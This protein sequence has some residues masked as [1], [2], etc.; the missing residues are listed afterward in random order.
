MNQ[1]NSVFVKKAEFFR[2]MVVHFVLAFVIAPFITSCSGSKS[3]ALRSTVG[4]KDA[5]TVTPITKTV[6][7]GGTVNLKASGGSGAYSFDVYYG[8]G[9]LT[10][11]GDTSTFQAPLTEGSAVV[12][13]QDSDSGIGYAMIDISDA[14]VI[15]PTSKTL[16]VGNKF[17]F[18]VMRG[19]AP[20]SFAVVTGPGTI[21]ATTGEFTAGATTGNVTVRVTDAG[22]RTADANVTVNGAIT[23]S[24]KNVY[25]QKESTTTLQVTGG[26]PPYRFAMASGLGSVDASTGI[27]TAPSGLGASG[28]YV[29]DSAGNFDLAIVNTTS[30]L[31]ISPS[32][33]LI[34]KNGTLVFSS[35][36][37]VPPYQFT[38]KQGTG[39]IGTLTGLYMAPGSSTSEVIEV[40]DGNGQTSDATV[41]VTDNLSFSVETIALAVGNTVDVSTYVTGGVQPLNYLAGNGQGTF[42]GS[43]YT[44]PNVP[45]VYTV[46]VNDSSAPTP[47]SVTTKMIVN[48]A[49]ILSPTSAAVST[50]GKKSFSASGGV[51]PYTYGMSAGGGTINPT[52]GVYMAPGS[53]S[54]SV[55]VM[56]T[57]ARGN[58]ATANVTVQNPLA[59]D[60]NNK[61]LSA[62][63][64]F[65]FSASGGTGNYR[66]S[67]TS[68][69]IDPNTGVYTAPGSSGLGTVFVT[70]GVDTVS[71]QI[72]VLSVLSIKPD[73]INLAKGSSMQFKGSG[74]SGHY[75]YSVIGDGT[76][77]P[78]GL[79]TAPS[80][81]K[82]ETVR[83]TDQMFSSVSADAQVVVYDGLTISPPTAKLAVNQTLSFTGKYGV[84]GY[85]FTLK[86]GG[87]GSITTD[88]VYTSGSQAGNATV[89][90]TDKDLNTAEALVTVSSG[91]QITPQQKIL[92]VNN[93]WT[94][95]ASGGVPPYKFT[96]SGGGTISATG[97][98]T[99]P[100]T[101]ASNV[102]VTVTDS[103]LVPSEATATVT[104][105]G[106]LALDPMNPKVTAGGTV[107]FTP[108]GGSV[109][110]LSDYQFSILANGAGSF[111]GNTY[112]APSDPAGGSATIQVK[113]TMG[114]TVSTLVTVMP[115]SVAITMPNSS[116]KISSS[117]QSAVHVAGTCTENGRT[118]HVAVS[119]SSVTANPTCSANAWDIPALDMSSVAD[120][121]V[122][123]TADHA[124]SFGVNAVQSSVTISKDGSPPTISISSPTANAYVG[125]SVT[126]TGPCTKVGSVTV[127]VGGITGSP[128]C[129]GT[130]YSG[131][132]N[133]TSL[134]DGPLTIG[135]VHTDQTGNISSTVSVNVIKDGTAPTIS[136]FTITN[137]SPTNN[138][139]FNL[140]STASDNVGI[141]SYC[142]LENN[143]LVSS[144]TWVNGSSLP[145]S[146][147][148]TNTNIGKTL[149]AWV[150]DAAGNIS[151]MAS[152]GPV[153]LDTVVPD[154]PTSLTVTTSSPNT[155][156]TPTISVGGITNGDSVMIYDGAGCTTQVATLNNAVVT[157]GLVTLTSSTLTSGTHEFHAKRRTAAGNTSLCSTASATYVLDLDPPT[158]TN[159]SATPTTGSYGLGGV[160]TIQVTFSENVVVNGNPR[161]YL[162]LGQGPTASAAVYDPTTSANNVL[163]FK[164]T[165]AANDS[166]GH[167]DYVSTSSFA[168]N[169]ATIKDVLQNSQTS[170]TLPVPGA[171]GSLGINTTIS[172]ITQADQAPT[173]VKVTN[174]TAS[175]SNIQKP[176]IQVE[177]VANQD[178]VS[179]FTDSNC[180]VANLI[181]TGK[182]S[183]A[184]I[185]VIPSAN[186]PE[187]GGTPY[188]FYANRKNSLGNTSA[189]SAASDPYVVDITAPTVQNVTSITANGAYKA[190]SLIYIQI[191]FSEPVVV[192][193]TPQLAMNTSVNAIYDSG[194]NTTTLTF[195]YTVGNTDNVDY[196]DYSSTSALSGTIKDQAGNALSAVLATPGGTGSLR[197]NKHITLDTTAPTA[198]S[199]LSL[200]SP[201]SS[202][203]N[204]ATPTIR[205]SGL[206]SGDTVN[207]FA[208]ASGSGCTT[209]SKVNGVVGANNSSIDLTSSALA[210]DPAT[211][212]YFYANSTDVAGNVS[213]C[214]SVSAI[215][216][217]DTTQARVINVTASGNGPWKAADTFTISIQFNKTV[218]VSGTAPVLNLSTTRA[219]AQ[220]TFYS[221]SGST[222]LVFQYQVQAGDTTSAASPLSYTNVNALV[223]T[224][225]DNAGNSAILTL[226]TIGQTGS[227]TANNTVVLDTTAPT[228]PTN[229]LDGTWFSS[230]TSSPAITF[231]AG[232]DSGSGIRKHQ[233]QIVLGSNT[234]TVVS[235]WADITNGSS[236]L[237]LNLTEGTLYKVQVKSIDNA[238][239]EAVTTGDGWTV[240]TTNPTAPTG[241]NL[242]TVPYSFSTTPTLTWTAGTDATSG[243]LY[244]QAQVYKSDNS[245]V[246]SPTALVNGAAISGLNLQSGSQYY[247][248]INAVDQAGNPSPTAQSLNWTAVEPCAAPSPTVGTVC[249]GGSIYAGTYNT[250]QYMIMP[251]NCTNSAT[252]TCDG[253]TDTLKLAFATGNGGNPAN[254]AN[255]INTTDGATNTTTLVAYSDTDAAKFC[256]NAI[257]G[258]YSDW[259]LPAK[260]ELN[261]I[262]LNRATLPGFVT[263]T[264]AW[265]LTSSSRG[266]GQPWV[267]TFSGAALY[268]SY[269]ADS[270]AYYIRCVRK[271]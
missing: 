200:I 234:S 26:A 112:T 72:T 53:T 114:N 172:V 40:T 31:Q 249:S 71:S 223:G 21:D 269:G 224:L 10:S 247:I 124:N 199:G 147:I 225:V 3:G 98:Y 236:I 80:T 17:P 39:T 167:L 14:P 96:V 206:S 253:N 82:T 34:A 58:T 183:G 121:T 197:A 163:T 222:T 30:A 219:G 93:Q 235:G 196:L 143:N 244:Y 45:G 126:V 252:P 185:L 266:S 115:V 94:F 171:A 153:I 77:T 133:I 241:L 48:S 28:V 88:G 229:V 60:P 46:T 37:G 177:G 146:Y 210:G 195:K 173:L 123:I 254:P 25:V 75:L 155:V 170:P 20:Y 162:N 63:E 36:G 109:I 76:I 136:A 188:R 175:P 259:F 190:G 214:S 264:G 158:I 6:S 89:I 15:Q 16:S 228:A 192:T 27:F 157:G 12:R 64:V 240:D 161:L 231:N 213:A 13:V 73:T 159:V 207:L 178:D 144:C 208:G 156:T 260:D 18:S 51:P 215:Y 41:T 70:D 221:G 239:N 166:S 84:P 108:T 42:S 142:I 232:T 9:T 132:L 1:F 246:G 258:G 122:V 113:D 66:F 74:G 130:S 204:I 35:I 137:T 160:I 29:F 191:V 78:T 271:Y 149:Y 102:T 111:S 184:T 257:Y 43:Q 104:V 59:I 129:D 233:A 267:Y 243:I 86:P 22:G 186:L 202:P 24:N 90:V 203:G 67:V 11:S 57:D 47:Y 87:V 83:V 164:Y 139:T 5:L 174:P 268:E 119:G 141:T 110:S 248:K 19:K 245:P 263:T 230:K 33:I 140:T 194:S 181:A 7:L 211:T 38:V 99:A 205:I 95:S 250:K 238:G 209:G 81:A 179:V 8:N 168:L 49:L 180:S 255:I 52:T 50:N 92:A 145:S 4:G 187:N 69:N 265:Y 101:S 107:V 118:V 97:D 85:K 44:A 134:N 65:T 217:L 103:G 261:M 125:N 138:P 154:A 91:L 100:S 54:N 116:S 189:C 61:T 165:V 62:G 169:G 117:N 131:T 256:N 216:Q 262:V 227:L 2:L 270:T 128:T 151:T 220:A 198:P 182:S 218:T 127:S 193:G 56:V 105:N 201:A 176:T 148:V 226:P 79:Y 242:G 152:A 32:N 251:G 150:K 135:V 106:P 237:G 55:V 68:G 120:G 212:Y 23:F